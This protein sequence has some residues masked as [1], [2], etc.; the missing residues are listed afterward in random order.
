MFQSGQ[1]RSENDNRHALLFQREQFRVLFRK[2]NDGEER[3]PSKERAEECRHCHYGEK[4]AETRTKTTSLLSPS[5]TVETLLAE[6]GAAYI[7][8]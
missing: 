4:V 1:M 8:R 6:S 2:S 5:T 3:E 7:L